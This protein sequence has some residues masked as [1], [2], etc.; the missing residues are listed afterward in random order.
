MEDMEN[1]L[2][3]RFSTYSTLNTQL[4]AAKARVQERTP[5]F[6]I[7]K[8]AEVPIKPTGPKRMIFVIACLF[9]AFVVTSVYILAKDT[10]KDNRK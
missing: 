5:A 7:I 4:Q 8:G 1:D 3:L 6:T 2:Q 10:Q 9:L